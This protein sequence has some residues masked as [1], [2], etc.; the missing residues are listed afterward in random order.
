MKTEVTISDYIKSEYKKYAIHTLTSRGIPSFEDCL[1]P[2][3][4]IILKNA[5]NKL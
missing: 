4:R 3:Q 2:I 1:T 5:I